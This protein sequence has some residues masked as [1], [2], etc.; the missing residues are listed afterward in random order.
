LQ[1]SP[2][3]RA[4]AALTAALSSPSSVSS[5][6]I[7]N[8]KLYQRTCSRQQGTGQAGCAAARPGRR[9]A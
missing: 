6:S 4:T 8:W 7:R 3:R 1:A 2:G 5:S 9:R